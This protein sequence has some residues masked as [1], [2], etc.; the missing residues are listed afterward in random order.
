MPFFYKK[1]ISYYKDK[2]VSPPSYLYGGNVY[3]VKTRSLWGDSPWCL[4]II[5]ENGITGKHI[6]T[7]FDSCHR[8]SNL[9]EIGFKS[10]INQ[11]VSPWNLMNDLKNNKAPFL[12]YINICAS[13]QIHQWIQTGVTVQKRS[14]RVKI[15]CPA[16]P[17]NLMDV[18]EKQ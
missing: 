4:C 8:P 11:P 12:Y 13:F 7:G 6:W 14:I 10:S 2:I 5:W 3:T 17:W 1:T 15:F 16:W 18:L 9:T